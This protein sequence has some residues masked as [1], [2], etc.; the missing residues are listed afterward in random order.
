[1][2]SWWAMP[3]RIV[4]RIPLETF[5]PSVIILSGYPSQ[6]KETKR[7][8]SE[9]TVGYDMHLSDILGTITWIPARSDASSCSEAVLRC[10]CDSE[11]ERVRKSRKRV[12]KEL[13][14]KK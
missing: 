4:A 13:K 9:H 12:G 7:K 1:M 14:E 3:K 6:A 11:Y 10:D 8:Y 5:S 2:L